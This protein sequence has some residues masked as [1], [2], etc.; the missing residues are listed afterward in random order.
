[1]ARVSKTVPRVAQAMTVGLH[2]ARAMT[3]P[4]VA[5]MTLWPRVVRERSSV[6]REAKPGPR[7]ARRERSSQWSE[8]RAQTIPG[9]RAPWT[10]ARVE[11]WRQQRWC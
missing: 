1:M 6:P 10:V 3:V 2:V 11:D 4:R 7:V 9:P 8:R 5:R